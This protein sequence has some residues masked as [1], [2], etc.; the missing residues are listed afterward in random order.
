MSYD[1]LNVLVPVALIAVILYL[2]YRYG[3]QEVLVEKGGDIRTHPNWW[4]VL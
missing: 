4:P 1:I 3:T 2:I